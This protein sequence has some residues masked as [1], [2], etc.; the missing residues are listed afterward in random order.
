MSNGTYRVKEDDFVLKVSN[1]VDSTK[2][3]ESKYYNFL[4][5]LCKNRVYQKE[6]ILTTLRLFCGGRY[7]STRELAEENFNNNDN[8]RNIY[9]TLNNFIAKLH[10]SNSFSASID[11]ATAT[12]KSWVIYGVAAIMLACNIVDQVLILVPSVTIEEELTKKIKLFNYKSDNLWETL[13]QCRDH[14]IVIDNADI[15]LNDD[16]RRF[17]NFEFSNQYML[18]S[19]NCDG[20]NVSDKSFKILKVEGNRITLED[21]AVDW[22]RSNSKIIERI[23]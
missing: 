5:E 9:G 12:G 8:I 21:E 13:K 7:N 14:F 16:I 10:F 22:F 1:S 15:L 2:W 19:R 17:I 11:L 18:F 4:N 6:A 23:N 20:L 3:D